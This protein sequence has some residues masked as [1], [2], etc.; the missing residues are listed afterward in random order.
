[1]TP[2]STVRLAQP[3]QF[4][5]GFTLIEL[6]VVMTLLSIIM[7]GLVS[8]LR[9]MAQTESKIDQRLNRLDE[10]R[11]ARSF[12]QQTLSRVSSSPIDAPGATGVKV[13]PFE[14]QANSLT[15]VGVMPARPDAGGRYHF[16]LALDNQGATRELV[17][18]FAP[19]RPDGTL[20]DW[21]QSESR[22]LVTGI[23]NLKIEAQG[24][25]PQARNPAQIWPKGWQNGWPVTDVL[26]ERVRLSLEDAQ[27]PWPEWTLPLHAMSQNDG[28]F[29]IVVIGGSR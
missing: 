20:P 25:A 10:I 5:L 6:L 22:V 1:M 15:W 4:H 26:P 12:L 13:I 14:A 21:S 8:A 16:R 3:N 18:R 9:T 23:E 24:L 19:W 29:S 2:R 28:S 7:I 11:V 17:L 27:G